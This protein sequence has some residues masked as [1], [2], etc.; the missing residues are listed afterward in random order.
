MAERS[1]RQLRRDVSLI[2]QNPA[3]SF[4]PRLRVDAILAEAVRG[5]GGKR[6]P[7]ALAGDGRPARS[8]GCS[9]IIRMR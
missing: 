2:F 1:F 8:P 4:N 9:T 5:L 3:G 6:D 7:A